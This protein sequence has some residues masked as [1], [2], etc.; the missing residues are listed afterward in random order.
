MTPYIV[1]RRFLAVDP[2]Q[3][4]DHCPGATTVS[5]QR[6]LPTASL[7]AEDSGNTGALRTWGWT[8]ATF[9]AGAILGWMV[10]TKRA[11]SSR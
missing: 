2:L 11:G 10:S 3:G 4:V 1:G 7:R 8:A 9:S 5:N 6:S